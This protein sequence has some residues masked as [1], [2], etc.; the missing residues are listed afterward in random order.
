MARILD[1]PRRGDVYLADFDPT[2]GSEIRKARP[3]LIVQNDIANEYSPITIVA[4]ITS[5]FDVTIRPTEA[6]IEAEEGG[7]TKRSV[8]LMNQI[9]SFDRARL[10]KRL[11]RVSPETLRRVDICL[12]RSLGLRE[13]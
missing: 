7:L 3:A 10:I 2:V 8:V 4:A 13:T 5:K 9:R 1:F 6:L 11:G 12:G